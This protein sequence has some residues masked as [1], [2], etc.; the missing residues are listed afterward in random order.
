[1]ENETPKKSNAGRHKKDC[2]CPK[3]EAKRQAPAEQV[4]VT[5]P[6][7]EQPKADVFTNREYLENYAPAEMFSEYEIVPTSDPEPEEAP[8]PEPKPHL[9]TGYLLLILVDTIIPLGLAFVG[10]KITKKPVT[11]RELKL[12]PDEKASLKELADAAAEQLNVNVPPLTMFLITCTMIY[13]S[14]LMK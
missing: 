1:M 7:I 2:I 14:K 9:V 3:C 11:V 4:E 8:R 5:P 13:G 6:H 10:P 12:T